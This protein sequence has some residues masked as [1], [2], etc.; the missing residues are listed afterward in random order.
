VAAAL[1]LGRSQ[2]GQ[3]TMTPGTGGTVGTVTDGTVTA[4]TVTAGTVT[5]G[6]TTAGGT[7][8]VLHKKASALHV[9]LESQHASAPCNP[10]IP[11]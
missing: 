11:C 3:A 7:A 1:P 4:G 5:A 9:A 8:A 6:A 2:A 10:C